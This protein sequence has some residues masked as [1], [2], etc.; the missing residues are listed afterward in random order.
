MI[1][2]KQIEEIGEEIVNI[3][4]KNGLSTKEMLLVLTELIKDTTACIEDED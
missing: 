4:E 3:F 2:K 1:D